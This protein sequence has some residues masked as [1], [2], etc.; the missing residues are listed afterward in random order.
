M[1]ILERIRHSQKQE[2]TGIVV[3]D[4]RAGEED[5]VA[6][7]ER[8]VVGDLPVEEE[9]GL[10]P[11]V[12]AVIGR[13]LGSGVG[14]GLWEDEQGRGESPAGPP[15]GRVRK[16]APRARAGPGTRSYAPA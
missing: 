7:G 1:M 13:L 16:G 3:G 6:D 15:G 8:H 10:E 2:L 12:M 4:R 11:Q 5:A 14:G 9:I